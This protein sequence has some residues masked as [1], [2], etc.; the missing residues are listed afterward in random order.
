MLAVSFMLR[1]RLPPDKGLTVPLEAETVCALVS[2][3][4]EKHFCAGRQSNPDL[5]SSQSAVATPEAGN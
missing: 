3:G 4:K 1:H 5:S 2:D